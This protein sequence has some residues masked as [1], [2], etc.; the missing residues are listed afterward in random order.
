[1]FRSVAAVRYLIL[2][3]G[4]VLSLFAIHA[5]WD[6]AL[7]AWLCHVLLLRFS[8]QSRWWVAGLWMWLVMTLD[9][10]V[11]MWHAE[12][13]NPAFILIGGALSLVFSVPYLIDRLV[14]AR[15]GNWALVSTLAFPLAKVAV[16]FVVSTMTPVGGIYGV[17][18]TTQHGNLPLAQLASVTGVYGVSFMVAW[19]ASVT[20]TCWQHRSRPRWLRTTVVTYLSVLAVVLT[21]GGARIV[22]STSTDTTVR[23]AGVAPS[24]SAWAHTVGALAPYQSVEELNRADPAVLREAFAHVVDDLLARSAREAGAGA[25]LVAWPESAVVTM[26]RDES[27][28]L[29]GF[30]QFA[31]RHHIY[32]SAGMTVYTTTAPYVR[33]QTVLVAP[34]GAPV[35]AYQK[36]HPIPVLEPYAAGDGVVPTADT[37]FGRLATA[38]CFDMNFPALVRHAG[39]QRADV[40]LAPSNDWRGIKDMHAQNAR[41]RAIENGYTLVRPTTE[42]ISEVVD[43]LGRVVAASDYFTSGDDPTMVAQV[44]TRGTQT[45]YG[46]V[47]DLFGWLCLTALAGLVVVAIRT[48]RTERDCPAPADADDV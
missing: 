36:A 30:R 24:P 17:L 45:V 8:R 26:A 10:A 20:V 9:L 27:A 21:A 7:A 3:G 16:E 1:M 6:V 29:A 33:N 14:A 11:W 38:I 43:H 32:L 13:G 15:L 2:L 19:F 46:A 37:P 47:G 42:G 22:S 25:K 31:E 18:G 44:P 28:L 12:L 5:R 34:S 35:W 23:M 40:M 39:Q 48:R 41:F 4:C